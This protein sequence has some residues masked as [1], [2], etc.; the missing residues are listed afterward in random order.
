MWLFCSH[1]LPVGTRLQGKTAK[2]ECPQC[3]KPEDIRHMAFD[4]PV[5]KYVRK[6]VF[7]EWW[8]HTTDSSWANHPTFI[9][10][11]FFKG[12]NVLEIA[13][14]CPLPSLPFTQGGR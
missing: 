6:M 12:D 10:C 4:C 8:A 2:I 11:F 14:T 9:G 7:K 5:A 13:I 1:A 3:G